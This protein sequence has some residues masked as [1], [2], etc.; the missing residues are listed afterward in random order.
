MNLGD[1]DF[2]LGNWPTDVQ[3]ENKMDTHKTIYLVVHPIMTY[4]HSISSFT[5]NIKV[6]GLKVLP[7]YQEYIDKNGNDM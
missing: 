4:G 3:I 1:I 5:D 6:R 7:K 2:G